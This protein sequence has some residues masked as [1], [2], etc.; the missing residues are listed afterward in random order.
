[1]EKKMAI[2]AKKIAEKLNLSPSAV[3]LALNGK[4]GV[5]DSTRELVLAEAERLGY[6][7]QKVTAAGTQNIRFVIFLGDQREIIQE[8]TF[9]SYILQGIEKYARRL[10]YNILVS[11]YRTDEDPALQLN[12]ISA[13]AAG[14]I[15]LG[16]S[17]ERS[18]VDELRPLFDLDLPVVMVDNYI[19]SLGIDCVVT[20]NYRGSYNATKY[21]LAKNY[22]DPGYLRS[23][24]K[25]DNFRRRQEGF[26]NACKEANPDQEC[27]I[28]DVGIS[29]QKA[30]DDMSEWLADGN[31]PPRALLADNDVIA[32]ACTRALKA[33][34]YRIPEDVAVI[35]FDNMPLCTMVEPPLTA[36]DVNKEMIGKTAVNLLHNRITECCSGEKCT[37]DG[38]LLVYVSTR[39]VE[40]E[41]T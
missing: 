37:D 3:S 23:R 36:I 31:H 35:G 38:T 9:Y 1:M 12:T 41:T 16:T 20:D 30:Y 8:T 26:L 14:L 5:S 7:R 10:G 2:T 33:H 11:Y 29:S 18:R 40:R 32:A 17:I 13:D 19:E 6:T 24:S 15:I 39:L 27:T 34:G 4:P 25:I 21:L 22:T 28:I